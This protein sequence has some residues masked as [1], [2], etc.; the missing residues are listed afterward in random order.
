LRSVPAPGRPCRALPK[1]RFGSRRRPGAHLRD[2]AQAMPQTCRGATKC[3]A[4]RWPRRSATSRTRTA[5]LPRSG[6]RTSG[7]PRQKTSKRCVRVCA[8]RDKQRL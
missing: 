6:T 1:P 2:L 7:P 4:S 5:C 3:S 8:A